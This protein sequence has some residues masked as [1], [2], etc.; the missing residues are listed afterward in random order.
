MR[1]VLLA[2]LSAVF[3]HICDGR[4]KTYDDVDKILRDDTGYKIKARTDKVNLEE[5][6]KP[7]D[8]SR[9]IKKSSLV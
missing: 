8:K 2:L 1:V 9:V 7:I 4:G 5:E 6:R 3:L